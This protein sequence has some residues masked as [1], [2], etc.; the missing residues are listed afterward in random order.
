[1]VEL[2]VFDLD[3]TLI[4]SR[5]DLAGAVNY[6]RGTMNLE[7][8][9]ESRIVSFLGNGI[10]SLVR[11][12]IA[13]ADIDFDKALDRMKKFY[14]DHLVESTVLYPGVAAGLKELRSSGML[15]A[16]VTNKPVRHAVKILEQLNVAGCF[17]DII[18]G[19]S[20]Y[21]LKPEPD[22]L[23]ALQKKY[24]F[25][26]GNCWM[27]GDH[28]TDMEAGRRAGFRRILVTYG[29]GDPQDETPDYTVDSFNEFVNV[30]R[31]F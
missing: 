4:D 5:R 1:M 31:K 17:S 29:F 16:V 10:N 20:E 11:R 8:L 18:G 25:K 23:L 28:Y 24:N 6:M 30:I 3:G 14:A 26:S 19:D 2:A 7:P 9:E 15:L 13:D 27:V 21:P 22:S 12:A